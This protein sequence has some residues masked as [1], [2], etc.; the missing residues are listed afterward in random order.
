MFVDIQS[1]RQGS[2]LLTATVDEGGAIRYHGSPVMRLE[3]SESFRLNELTHRQRFRFL[4][5]GDKTRMAHDIR[6]VSPSKGYE[7]I[8]TYSFE[9]ESAGI[10]CNRVH[11]H[12]GR[13][14]IVSNDLYAGI[15][16]SAPAQV[17]VF[18]PAAYLE[19]YYRECLISLYVN[20]VGRWEEEEVIHQMAQFFQAEEDKKTPTDQIMQI[21][22]EAIYT[23]AYW[24]GFAGYE[25]LPV[26]VDTHDIRHM[27]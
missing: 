3:A 12:P 26:S 2:D 19:M 21:A 18:V 1:L 11:A 23:V 7:R 5:N 22:R 27:Y 20:K 6:V 4:H 13:L 8:Y 15:T 16:G 24:R 10:R 9:G 25:P 17:M 14:H